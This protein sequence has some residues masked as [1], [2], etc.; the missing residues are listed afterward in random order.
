ME[1]F[2]KPEYI[3]PEGGECVFCLGCGLCF[4]GGTPAPFTPLGVTTVM[5]LY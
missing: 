1:K 3:D 5:G 2:H 4:I